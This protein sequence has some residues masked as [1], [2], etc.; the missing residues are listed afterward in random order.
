MTGQ[1]LTGCAKYAGNGEM[2]ITYDP[3][4]T[5]IPPPVIRLEE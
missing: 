5:Y 1:A 4:E 2:D 3:E